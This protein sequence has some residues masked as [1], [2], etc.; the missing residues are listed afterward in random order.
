MEAKIN[1]YDEKNLTL[2]RKYIYEFVLLSLCSSTIFLFH[3]YS[4]LD[5]SVRTYLTQDRE[6]MIQ[7]INNNTQALSLVEN[8]IKK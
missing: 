3:E 5:A 7:V 6:K 1:S 2:F 4:Q 8:L